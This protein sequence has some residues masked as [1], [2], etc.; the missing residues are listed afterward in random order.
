[1]KPRDES[2]SA[3]RVSIAD[4]KQLERIGSFILALLLTACTS[5]K[6]PPPPTVVQAVPAM[7]CKPVVAKMMIVTE[8]ERAFRLIAADGSWVS[9]D[10]GETDV[11]FGTPKCSSAWVGSIGVQGQ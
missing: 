1:M 5:A 9:V 10:A 2:N 7:T 4:R 3:A 6:A 8:H 11:K